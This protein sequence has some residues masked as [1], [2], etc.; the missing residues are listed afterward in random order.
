MGM[1]TYPGAPYVHAT[2]PDQPIPSMGRTA[3]DWTIDATCL[4]NEGRYRLKEV[5]VQTEII[6]HLRKRFD[7]LKQ[8]SITINQEHNHVGDYK[9]WLKTAKVEAE[10]LE[11]KL[12]GND[13]SSEIDCINAAKRAMGGMMTEGARITTNQS[14]LNWDANGK[15]TY[16]DKNN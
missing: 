5:S 14:W 10:A 3:V 2:T 8:R 15:H 4:C 6:I 12:Q 1:F 16:Y 7:D 13:Y 11:K 9:E